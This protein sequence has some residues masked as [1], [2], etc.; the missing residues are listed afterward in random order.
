MEWGVHW[1]I[2]MRTS[3]LLV[4]S[5][6]AASCGNYPYWP[7]PQNRSITASLSSVTMADDCGGNA[8]ADAAAPAQRPLDGGTTGFGCRQSS[9]QLTFVSTALASAT[10][11]IREI[12]VLNPAT[13]VLLGK[14]TS[15]EPQQWQV[16]KYVSWNEQIPAQSTVK[17]SYKTS[18]FYENST[19][20]RVAGPQTYLIEVDVAIDGVVRTVSAEANR[21]PIV[22]T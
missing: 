11:Q 10:V 8:L 9:I 18:A 6:I 13:H 14:L 16:D 2:A 15:R 17:A 21:E 5:L 12:R 4:V 20:F 3:Q 1:V 22:V 19:A 7:K